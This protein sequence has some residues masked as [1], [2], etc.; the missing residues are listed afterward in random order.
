MKRYF[1]EIEIFNI[2]NERELFE[3]GIVMETHFIRVKAKYVGNKSTKLSKAIMS[4][5]KH[6]QSGDTPIYAESYNMLSQT[7]GT[8]KNPKQVTGFSDVGHY[9]L[10]QKEGYFTAYNMLMLLEEEYTLIAYSSSERFV[11]K[12]HFNEQEIILEQDLGNIVVNP[13]EEI[14]LEEIMMQTGKDRE[15]LLGVLGER[16]GNHHKRLHFEP[17]PT[18][19]CSWYY[20]GP[21]VT[22]EDIY[23]N[24]KSLQKNIPQFKYIQ[25]D[26]GYQA[27]MGDYLTAADT[28][29]HLPE[30]IKQI[31]EQG[32]EP[33]I[34]VAPFIA[35][36]DSAIFKEHPEYF[37][38]DE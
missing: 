3:C 21:D 30:L 33:A 25:I 1:N 27:Y 23:E 22:Q 29:K 18:G 17:I 24:M 14:V 26:D 6:N 19:W 38:K 13:G 16:L 8:L 7:E 5:F 34:W 28:F 37:V 9:K 11:G 35:E 4:R 36:A 2:R 31:K 32:F 10:P 20:Y 15:E 12:I